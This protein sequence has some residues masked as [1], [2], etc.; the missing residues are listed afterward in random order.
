MLSNSKPHYIV[1]ALNYVVMLGP[2]FAQ[3]RLYNASTL[4]L[5]KNRLENV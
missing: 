3:K 1:N 4:Q 5:M 2:N